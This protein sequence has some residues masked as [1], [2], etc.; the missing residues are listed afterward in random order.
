V[1][2]AQS[3]CDDEQR[4]NRWCGDAV[5]RDREGRHRDLKCFEW[6]CSCSSTLLLLNECIVQCTGVLSALRWMVVVYCGSRIDG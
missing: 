3:L 1:V 5:A 4:R 6:A 2:Y